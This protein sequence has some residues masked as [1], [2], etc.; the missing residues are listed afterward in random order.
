MSVA[1]HLGISLEEYDER[2]RTFI[3]YYEEML[4]AAAAALEPRAQVIV[5][6]GIGTGGLAL[7]CLRAAP[8]A[9]IVGI[10]A[11][12]AVLPMAERRL[13]KR[14]RLISGDL[15]ITA[16]P[17][18]DAMVSSFAL[19]H[20]RT[21]EA[22]TLLYRRV[23]AALQ[24]QGV[25][26]NADCCPA[27][28]PTLAARQRLAWRSHLRNTYTP[29]QTRGFFRA[30]GREDVYLPL[31]VERQILEKAGFTVEITWRRDAFAVL[32]ARIEY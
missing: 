26:I 4:D 7:R 2:I 21:R 5:D 24:P 3:P 15:E 17:R 23:R 29:A 12:A 10:D 27:A 31:N 9:R 28:D 18:C 32:V 6:L 8:R 13:G 22:K 1:A 16:L 20:V 11:D 25:L 19:H 30:W 14:A